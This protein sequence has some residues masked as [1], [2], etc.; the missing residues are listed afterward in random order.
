M[1]YMWLELWSYSN[2]PFST[3]LACNCGAGSWGSRENV[4]R[5]EVLKRRGWGLRLSSREKRTLA[6][7]AKTGHDTVNAVKDNFAGVCSRH[8]TLQGIFCKGRR[9]TAK[10]AEYGFMVDT[11]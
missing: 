1:Q 3:A 5:D 7:L 10:L 4:L 11:F 8:A 9:T 2:F 6:V